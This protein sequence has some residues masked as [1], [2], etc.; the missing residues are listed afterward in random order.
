VGACP[1]HRERI[2]ATYPNLGCDLL[3]ARP[4]VPV[5]DCLRLVLVAIRSGRPAPWMP[6]STWG[7]WSNGR[8]AHAPIGCPISCVPGSGYATLAK[9]A[10]ATHDVGPVGE[11]R[12]AGRGVPPVRRPRL[13]G[14]DAR[15]AIKPGDFLIGRPRRSPHLADAL[16]APRSVAV[17]CAGD[18]LRGPP[19]PDFL[20]SPL[21][22]K[23][24]GD[25]RLPDPVEISLGPRGLCQCGK[26][27]PSVP[28]TLALWRTLSAATVGFD[29][30][31]PPPRYVYLMIVP[32][33]AT[34]QP[35]N[36]G[37]ER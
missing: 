36:I 24:P 33:P 1:A 19:I 11:R 3:A 27:G 7:F 32:G 20:Q 28:L 23:R 34:T 6:D 14:G 4:P 16:Q 5:R 15:A 29:R 2:R 37:D 9:A 21:A 35:R 30:Q 17:K 22:G 25:R 10:E 12:R 18:V 8:A 31:S 13:G 26:G